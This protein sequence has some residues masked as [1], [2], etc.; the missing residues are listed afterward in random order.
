M[1]ACWIQVKKISAIQESLGGRC[2]DGVQICCGLAKAVPKTIH[3]Q[4]MTSYCVAHA[5]EFAC[6]AMVKADAFSCCR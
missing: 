6:G 1:G 4:A 2:G 5:S 3:R